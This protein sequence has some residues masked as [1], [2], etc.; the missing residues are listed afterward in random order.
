MTKKNGKNNNWLEQ[1]YPEMHY[2]L[3]ALDGDETALDWLKANSSGVGVLARAITGRGKALAS[4]HADEHAELDDLFEVIDN[5]DLT[6]WL[7]ERR[8]ELH[9]LFAAIKGEPGAAGRLKRKRPGLARLALVVRE[10]Y[11]SHRHK[12]VDGRAVIEGA[13][14]DMGCLIGEMHL[15]QGDFA[16]A[17]E[18][19]TRAIESGPA[20]DLFEERARAYRGLAEQDERRAAELRNK[21]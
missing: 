21:R 6:R 19:F 1:A 2:M 20:P 5:D 17:V 7:E 3:L 12:E 11:D 15:K 16:R 8:P 18:A 9:L 4:L 10:L 13:A 14:A